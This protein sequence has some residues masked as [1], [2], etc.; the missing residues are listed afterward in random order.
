VAT[1]STR[2]KLGA[3]EVFLVDED[4]IAHAESASG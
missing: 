4:A 3:V 1:P 2:P